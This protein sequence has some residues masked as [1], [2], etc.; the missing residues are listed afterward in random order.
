MTAHTA[1][2]FRKDAKGRARDN[3]A[4]GSAAEGRDGPGLVVLD[5]EDG[6]QLRDL[7]QVVDFLGEVQ[8]LQ[9]ATLIADGG[10]GADQLADT[11]A[12][13]VADIA[14]V[15]QDFLLPLAQQVLNGVAQNDTALAQGDSPA[16][17]DDG[18]AVYLPSTCFHAHVEASWRP[19]S[20]L[21]KPLDQCDFSARFKFTE[22]DLIHERPH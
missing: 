11:R 16:Q 2:P 10:E 8:Q 14:Q 13:Y 7:K 21:G 18:D 9:L 6:V 20:L 1:T 5:V 3:V 4:N 19:P 22:T 15:Q 12:V 17:V